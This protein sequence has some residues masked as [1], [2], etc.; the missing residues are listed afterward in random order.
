MRRARLSSV[1]GF[2]ARTL[3]LFALALALWYLAREWV[4]LPAAWVAEHAM[5]IAFPGWALGTE[6]TGDA[7]TLLTRL[8]MVAPDGRVGEI[9]LDV[10]MLK[11][12]YGIPLLAALVI[13]SWPRGGWWKLLLGLVL[14]VP[15][16]AWGICAEWLLQVA[17]Y[18]GPAPARQAGFGPVAANLIGAAYQ[19]GFLMFPTLAPVL[20]WLA[21]DRKQ[22]AIVLLDG[23]VS[24]KHGDRQHGAGSI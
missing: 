14:L 23:A 19:L 16:Q 4:V 21:F 9:A 18:S 3:V 11:Y 12:C 7:L 15:F 10:R 2:F 20:V 6:R 24:A 8:A 22:I 13:A 17:L 1:G 5:Q